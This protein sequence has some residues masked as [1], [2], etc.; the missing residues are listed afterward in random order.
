MSQNIFVSIVPCVRDEFNYDTIEVSVSYSPRLN[1]C[2]MYID[3][4]KDTSTA[5]MQGFYTIVMKSPSSTAKL[6]DMKRDNK[7]KVAEAQS[8]AFA[9]IQNKSGEAFQHL[10]VFLDAHGFKLVEAVAA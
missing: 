7:K 9:E 8:K 3:A 6:L 1:G 10:Q 4:G 5:T 2:I